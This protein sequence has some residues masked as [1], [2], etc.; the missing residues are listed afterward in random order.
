[1]Q[2]AANVHRGRYYRRGAGN[3]VSLA[4]R[5]N[6][7]KWTLERT[8][9]PTGATDSELQSVSCT[10]ARACTAV[11]YDRN[12]AGRK[13]T[14]AERRN[15]KKWTLEPTLNPTEATYSE[16]E[17]VSCTGARACLAVGS[18]ENTIGQY[19]TLAER[20]NGKKWM[21]EPTPNPA[22]AVSFLYGS[23]VHLRQGCTAVGYYRRGA[24]K[25]VTFAER[26]NGKKWTI[27]S[28]PTPAGAVGSFLYGVSSRR[29]T[30]APR[31][32]TTKTA[33]GRN[34]RWRS[35]GTARCG[36]SSHAYPGCSCLELLLRGVVHGGGR[37]HRSRP[38]PTQRRQT[39]DSGG[40]LERQ[41]VDDRAHA[42]P[43]QRNIK[44]SVW[45]IL[46][47][48]GR[49]H[50]GWTLPKEGWA[51]IDAGRAASMTFLPNGKEPFLLVPLAA[52]SS[53]LRSRWPGGAHA[54]RNWSAFA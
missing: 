15:D 26:W 22:K 35:A 18:Y 6:G 34:R 2:L 49:V 47:G 24:V 54:L 11:G 48:R 7:K 10:S 52:A 4:E 38:L 17:S 16:L 28:M 9:N 21:I 42:Q 29:Q 14:L 13:S 31:S 32:G 8:P 25:I 19:V 44:L 36:R 39:I 45:R 27:E 5:W 40:V 43:G 33:P 41:E 30:P 53:T 12:S 1:M 37:L 20:W 50:R 51:E 3:F 23:V 46:H